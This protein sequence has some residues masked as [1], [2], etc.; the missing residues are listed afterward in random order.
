MPQS[1][2]HGEKATIVMKEMSA[3]V[4]DVVA[5]ADAAVV[6]GAIVEET[7]VAGI[8]I[9]TSRRMMCLRPKR[10]SHFH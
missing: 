8:E 10:R 5:V 6:E 7:G 9:E 1:A 2:K 3:A 4:A